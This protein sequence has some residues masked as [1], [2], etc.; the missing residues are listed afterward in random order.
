MLDGK[1]VQVF[2]SSVLKLTGMDTYNTVVSLCM[3]RGHW[4]LMHKRSMIFALLLK[5]SE[6]DWNE[7]S[8]VRVRIK[9]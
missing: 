7:Y 1:N 2:N 4:S 3:K 8:V 6:S 5:K 9:K